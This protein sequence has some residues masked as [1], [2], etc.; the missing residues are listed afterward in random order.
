M[1]GKAGLPRWEAILLTVG[2]QSP[3]L[4]ADEHCLLAG[5]GVLRAVSTLVVGAAD[6]QSGTAGWVGEAGGLAV[7]KTLF[8]QLRF[9]SGGCKRKACYLISTPCLALQHRQLQGVMK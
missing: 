7:G 3:S 8:F 5:C 6:V 2:G 9:R 4:P 1:E